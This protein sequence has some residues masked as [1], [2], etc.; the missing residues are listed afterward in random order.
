MHI[1]DI[2]T[3]LGLY[4]TVLCSADWERDFELCFSCKNR[5]KSWCSFITI[6]IKVS[7]RKFRKSY[8]SSMISANYCNKH[9]SACF[10]EFRNASPMDT[11]F[12]CVTKLVTALGDP[13]RVYARAEPRSRSRNLQFRV[14]SYPAGMLISL[15]GSAKLLL[16]SSATDIP[17]FA[18]PSLYLQSVCLS[19]YLSR[20]FSCAR[21]V[22]RY[23]SEC[24]PQILLVLSNLRCF[25]IPKSRYGRNALLVIP[26]TVLKW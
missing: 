14:R 4:P 18:L 15:T 25:S 22:P 23:W 20:Y 24:F 8:S 7:S 16:A 3:R 11:C 13:W 6:F 5:E 10:P 17:R 19:T 12:P 21:L 26:F 9:L 2:A 1:P